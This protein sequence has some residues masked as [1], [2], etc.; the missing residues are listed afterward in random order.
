MDDLSKI[1]LKI[2]LELSPCT[3]QAAKS[4][5]QSQ[6]TDSKLKNCGKCQSIHADCWHLQ[7]RCFECYSIDIESVRE[8]YA[9]FGND[10][11]DDNGDSQHNVKPSHSLAEHNLQVISN[12]SRWAIGRNKIKAKRVTTVAIEG[13]R[14]KLLL[15]AVLGESILDEVKLL[16]KIF[17]KHWQK[18]LG[19]L[20]TK[21]ISEL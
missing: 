16:L 18:K 10:D 15:K 3:Y 2:T 5:T 9:H 1:F 21:E 4:L 17:K 14:M 13:G 20:G 7:V 6:Y 11:K 12:T 8:E 19:T